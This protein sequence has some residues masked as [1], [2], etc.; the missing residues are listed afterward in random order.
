M[1]ALHVY[2]VS[3]KGGVYKRKIVCSKNVN[4][5]NNNVALLTLHQ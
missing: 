3:H 2:K 5:N 4:N 1:V